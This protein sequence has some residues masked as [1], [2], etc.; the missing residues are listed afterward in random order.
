MNICVYG[1]SSPKINEKY[2]RVGEKLGAKIAL[3][4]YGLVFGAGARGM[5]GAVARGAYKNNGDIIGIV[6]SFFDVDG[7]LFENCTEMIKT[8]DMRERKTLLENKSDAFIIT[9]GGIGTL[10][11]F[12][13]ILTLKQLARHNK[14]M[15]IFNSFGYYDDMINM[16]YHFVDEKYLFESTVKELIYITDDIDDAINYIKNYNYEKIIPQKYKDI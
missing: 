4:G 1:A 6:P 13:E 11:E 2:I 5:M 15:I 10:D 9:P 16:L 8:K 14:P 12:F 3:N 7:A